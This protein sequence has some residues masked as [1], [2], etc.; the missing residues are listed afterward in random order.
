MKGE[1]AITVISAREPQEEDLDVDLI[2][3]PAIL[4]SIKATLGVV[5]ASGKRKG[6]SLRCTS[7]R[8]L[9]CYLYSCHSQTRVT[10][11]MKTCHFAQHSSPMSLMQVVSPSLTAAIG[12]K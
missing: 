2:S 6:I 12:M 9:F 3:S 8:S 7:F 1:K 10:P 5:Q 11:G 4:S